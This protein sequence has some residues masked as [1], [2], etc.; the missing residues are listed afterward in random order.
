[1]HAVNARL[2]PETERHVNARD[3]VAAIFLASFEGQPDLADL[4][5][6]ARRVLATAG[7]LFYERGAVDTSVRD[8]TRACGLTPG[9]L[10]NHFASKDELLFT[11]VRHGHTRMR[12]RI[13]KAIAAAPS[14]PVSALRAFVSAYMVGHVENPELAQTVRREYLH[15]SAE[16]YTE[17]VEARRAMRGQLSGLLVDGQRAGVFALLGGE[18]GAVASALMVLDMCSRTSEWFDRTRDT[19]PA[20]II[21][22]YVEAA[23]RLVGADPAS[24]VAG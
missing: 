4:S 12:T 21:E 2:Y 20:G 19:D 3:R 1:M 13:D 24:R 10:Y 23:L 17:I 22:R 6:A 9:A 11:L 16:H 7:A 8:L 18:S 5:Q 15:L 14:D